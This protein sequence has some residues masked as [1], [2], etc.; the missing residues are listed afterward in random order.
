MVGSDELEGKPLI[1]DVLEQKTA[2]L[3]LTTHSQ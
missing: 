3:T 1:T 2:C